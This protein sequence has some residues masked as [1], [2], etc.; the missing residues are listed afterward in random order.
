MKRSSLPIGLALTCVLFALNLHAA[1]S[2]AT[3]CPLHQWKPH[4][5]GTRL[6]SPTPLQLQTHRGPASPRIID[7]DTTEWSRQVVISNKVSGRVMV[8]TNSFTELGNGH[9]YLGNDG[10]WRRSR[11]QFVQQG[12]HFVAE[13]GHHKVRL[14]NNLNQ[15]GAVDLITQSRVHLP[16]FPL[17]IGYYAPTTGQS[18]AENCGDERP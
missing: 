11:A 2:N 10:L 13:T 15:P 6:S 17:A 12:K 16:G 14:A 5:T 4:K 3:N 8:Q 9:N 1:T 7:S 18:P